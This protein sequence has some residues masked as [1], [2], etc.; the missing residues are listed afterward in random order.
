MESKSIVDKNIGTPMLD[1]MMH[2]GGS[3]RFGQHLKK[4]IVVIP[5][6]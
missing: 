2:I 5:F 4:T 1:V 6:C 3:T